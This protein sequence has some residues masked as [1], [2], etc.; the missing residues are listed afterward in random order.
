MTEDGG[1]PGR[2]ADMGIDLGGENAFVPQHFLHDTEIGTVLYEMRGERVAEGVRGY[3]L[4]NA[5][6][7]CIML[8]HIE[9]GNPAELRAAAV[10]EK[11][12]AHRCG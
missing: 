3:L 7:H 9:D 10:E 12:V 5:G 2:L 6:K 8:Y 4:G 11:D 1:L